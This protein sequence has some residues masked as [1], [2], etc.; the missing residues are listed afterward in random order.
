MEIEKEDRVGLMDFCAY[1]GA[2]WFVLTTII[3]GPFNKILAKGVITA[4]IVTGE[5]KTE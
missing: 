3:F 4:D 2:M 1:A 5:I